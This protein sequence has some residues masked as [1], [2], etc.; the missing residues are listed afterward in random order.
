MTQ[1]GGLDAAEVARLFTC[2]V[3]VSVASPALYD[4]APHPEEAAAVARAIE[5]RRREF[6]AGRAC[7][8][9]ALAQLGAEAPA[10]PVGPERAPVWPL[11]FVGSITHCDGFCCAVV[12]PRTTAASLG[13]DAEDAG[14]MDAAAARL[15]LRPDEADWL[16]RR[17]APADSDWTKLAFS[18]KE[19]VFKCV[20]PLTG[21]RLGFHGVAI[22]FFDSGAFEADFAPGAL[23]ADIAAPAIEGRW[24]LCRGRVYAGATALA[25]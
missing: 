16:A 20:H 1:S 25:R 22:R 24:R 10:I 3:A 2:P 4:L 5:K 17:P 7:A 15:I 19:A 6:A 14:R 9:E 13:V 11:G 21:A 23:P 18:A 12:A 8:R